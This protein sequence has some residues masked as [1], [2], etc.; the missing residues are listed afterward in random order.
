L[1][2]RLGVGGSGGHLGG[3]GRIAQGHELTHGVL[4]SHESRDDGVDG[5]VGEVGQDR[6]RRQEAD[7]GRDPE[8]V[9]HAE[10]VDGQRATHQVPEPHAAVHRAHGTQ[11]G[12]AL[13]DVPAHEAAGPAHHLLAELDG[14]V[15][16]AVRHA[17]EHVLLLHVTLL[18][19]GVGLE[20]REGHAERDHVGVVA[21]A[22]GV[23]VA[24]VHHA[25]LVALALELELDQGVG[26]LLRLAVHGVDEHPRDV[27]G[28]GD[29]LV[30]G[31]EA[32]LVRAVVQD[33][34]EQVHQVLDLHLLAAD[35]LLVVLAHVAE[36]DRLLPVSHG[37]G[38]VLVVERGLLVLG[39]VGEQG[40]GGGGRVGH[41]LV[42]LVGVVVGRGGG[43]RVGHGLALRL[44]GGALGAVDLPL[45]GDQVVDLLV[46]II[47]LLGTRLH[48][49][50]HALLVAED[51]LVG[52]DRQLLLLVAV[53]AVVGV[54]GGGRGGVGRGHVGVLRVVVDLSGLDVFRCPV[55]VESFRS[56][57][58]HDPP[59]ASAAGDLL[60]AQCDSTLGGGGAVTLAGD[61]VLSEPVCTHD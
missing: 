30:D 1:V 50:Q 45:L 59:T 7:A 8:D 51:L 34:L 19:V 41:G 9:A 44:G 26:R 33:G 28:Q 56:H 4:Q 18:V 60:R 2:A 25:G 32:V 20:G 38:E 14:H 5:R 27:T 37:G 42:I 35:D 58:G 39:V 24:G 52:D 12:V 47:L 6:V 3:D 43:G 61:V 16:D 21:L 23:A 10:H 31:V 53:G 57:E 15:L 49:F 29:V 40:R 22:P 48:V 13:L 55:S 17:D 46:H 36:D 54:G 11:D